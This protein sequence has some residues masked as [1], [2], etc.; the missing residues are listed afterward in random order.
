MFQ[1][2]ESTRLPPHRPGVD[3]EIEIEEGKRLPIKK[4]YPLGARELEELSRYIRTNEQRQWI[5]ESFTDGGSTIMFVKKKDGKLQLCV[6]YRELNNITKKDRYRLPLIGEALDQLQGA[7]FFMKLDIKDAYH[8][9]RIRKGDEWKTTFTTKLGTYEYLVMPIGLCN[10]PAAFQRWIN[11]TLHQFV[12]I[13]CIVYLDD[14]LIYSKDKE[15]HIRD[16]RS[17]LRAIRN[18]GIRIKPGKCEFHATETEYLGFIIGR[19]GIKVDPI[20]TAAIWEW[21]KPTK[22]KEVQKLMGFC[23]FY[24]RFIEGFSQK[25]RPL[26]QLIRK[27]KKWEWGKKENEAFN[28]IRTHLTSTPTLIHFDPQQPITIETD[29]SNYVTAGILTQPG[30]DRKL[31]PVAYRSKTMTKAECNYD[32]VTTLR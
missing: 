6:D 8:N 22:V 10:A 21:A 13:C 31:H 7:K 32:V 1:E 4:I 29:A 3:L 18:S 30:K 5:R 28:K 23:N 17:V 15:Q 24:R 26:Y 12:D 19:D 16:V 11:R 27:D 25:A 2:K 20:K 14:V 9:I